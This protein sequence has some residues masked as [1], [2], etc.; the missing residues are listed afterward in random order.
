RVSTPNNP[1]E[2]PTNPGTTKRTGVLRRLTIWFLLLATWEASYR[3]IGWR[4]W[5]F[6]APSHVLDAIVN[7]IGVLPQTRFG[8]AVSRGWPLAISRP[9]PTES[10]GSPLLQAILISAFRLCL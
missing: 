2:T 10:P 6:P 8:D 4:P 3:L 7:L 5:L 9:L 1:T